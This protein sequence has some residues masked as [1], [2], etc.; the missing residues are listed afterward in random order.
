MKGML[1]RLR[2]GYGKKLVALHTWNGWIVVI[3]ALTGLLLVGG[4]WRGLLGEGR[5]WLKWLHIAVGVASILPVIYYLLL[6]GKHWKQLRQK[7]WQRFNVLVVLALLLGWFGS[8]VLLWQFKAVGPRVSNAALTV[9]DL[10]TWIGLPYIIYHSLTRTK[11]LKEPARRSIKPEARPVGG[12]AQGHFR[13]YTVTDIPSFSNENW[14]FT[15]DGLVN[16][17]FKWSWEDFLKLK[18]KVQVSDFHCVTGWSVYNNTW[19]GIPL[20]ELLQKA[21]VKPNAKTVKF[22]SGGW[23][24]HRY[25]HLGSGEYGRLYGRGDAR[26]QADTER[27]GWSGKTDRAENVRLQVGEVAEPHRAHRRRACRILGAARLL[28][29]CVGRNELIARI[30]KEEAGYSI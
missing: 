4:F 10:L 16:N 13:V 22:Y 28:Q 15:I 25:P 30:V 12:G 21:G 6:A 8:G 29:R 2:K 3:L 20:R 9:H 24:L 14:S 17:K 27:L 11:W 23:R 7:P 26:R 5:V 19:E 1:E 18:R